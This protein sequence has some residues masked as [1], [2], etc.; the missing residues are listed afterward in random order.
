MQI[1]CV[2]C[3]APQQRDERYCSNCQ[4]PFGGKRVVLVLGAILLLGLQALLVLSGNAH[5]AIDPRI[6]FWYDLPVLFA[7]AF[8]YDFNPKRRSLYFW[9]G[10]A[11]IVASLIVILWS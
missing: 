4:A 7:T 10:S 8:F 3:G 2:Q 11:V 1:Y 6:L 5:A 9:G